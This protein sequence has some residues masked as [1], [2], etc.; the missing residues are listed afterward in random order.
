MGPF[1]FFISQKYVTNMLSGVFHGGDARHS[2]AP[3]YFVILAKCY[4]YEPPWEH[5]RPVATDGG[6]EEQE[7]D[8]E[9]QATIACPPIER[10]NG[11]YVGHAGYGVNLHSHFCANSWV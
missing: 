3:L 9:C 8:D 4:P 1:G 10:L 7:A 2:R 11:A 6:V 5:V